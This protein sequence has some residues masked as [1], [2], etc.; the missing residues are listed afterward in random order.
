M[1]VKQINIPHDL[2]SVN[3]TKGTD[4]LQIKV[5]ANCSWC[6]SDPNNVFSAGFL[7]AGSYVATNP[8]TT[9]GPYTPQNDGTVNVNA[10]TSG[11][12]SPTGTTATP[13]TIVVSG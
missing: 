12:C 5:T 2:S 6:Y 1:G 13:H 9:Y 4:T 7:A 10:V 8:P 11:T 3:L